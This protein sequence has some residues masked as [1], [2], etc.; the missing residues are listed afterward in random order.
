MNI[1]KKLY[2][3]FQI[4]AIS[5]VKVIRIGFKTSYKTI[6]KTKFYTDKLF[7]Y[8]NPILYL[9]ILFILK[10]ESGNDNLKAM[11]AIIIGCTSDGKQQK[12]VGLHFVFHLMYFAQSFI[13]NVRI[14]N[15]F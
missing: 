7:Q 15:L 1:S 9:V 3:I 14:C 6:L 12:V 10:L 5:C 8:W 13:V 4:F 11:S 2:T